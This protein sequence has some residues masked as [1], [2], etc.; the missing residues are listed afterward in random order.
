MK[1]IQTAQAAGNV[2]KT[3][4]RKSAGSVVPLSFIKTRASLGGGDFAD[5][6]VYIQLAHR[7]GERVVQILPITDTG[8]ENYWPYSAISSFAINPIFIDIAGFEAQPGAP[9]DM[10]YSGAAEYPKSLLAL[11][12]SLQELNKKEQIDYVAVR[13]GKLTILLHWFCLLYDAIHPQLVRFKSQ[14]QWVRDYGLF[15]T[16]SAHFQTANWSE[17]PDAHLK[18]HDAACLCDFENAHSESVWFYVFLQMVAFYQLAEIKACANAAGVLLKGDIPILAAPNSVDR[19]AHPGYFLPGY[20]AGAPPDMF[21]TG[22]QAWGNPPL[23]LDNPSAIDYFVSR[24]TLAEHYLD[25]I[26]IDHILGIFRILIWN[27]ALGNVANFGFFYPQHDEK[28]LYALRGDDLRSL[29]L[30]PDKLAERIGVVTNV[31]DIGQEAADVLVANRWAVYVSGRSQI[32]WVKRD[33][34]G[35]ISQEEVSALPDNLDANEDECRVAWQAMGLNREQVSACLSARRL[36][37]NLLIPYL[38]IPDAWVLTFYGR[39]TWHYH[40]L[41]ED[42]RQGLETLVS[43]SYARLHEFWEINGSRYLD[44]LKDKTRLILCG[45]DLGM[46]D[47]YI[48]IALNKLDIPGMIVQRWSATQR[49]TDQ[50]ENAIFTPSTHDTSTFIHWWHNESQLEERQKF[51]SEFMGLPD[52]VPQY[53]SFDQLTRIYLHFYSVNSRLMI[54]PFWEYLTVFHGAD[55]QRINVPGQ[56]LQENWTGRMRYSLEEI[57]ARGAGCD[58]MILAAIKHNER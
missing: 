42:T 57:E 54:L 38:D 18:S 48:P 51:W 40:N 46:V 8:P 9:F 47:P 53:L 25:V 1:H 34:E 3:G 21:T 11:K 22:G 41:S 2:S 28:N 13:N 32:A 7:R 39:E 12:K 6:K 30:S 43:Q 55:D 17:W 33:K 58:Q 56:L 16:I 20:G 4:L 49:A 23:D 44:I 14:H 37:Q 35:E 5:F 29:G 52:P 26:R 27:L 15:C 10:E 24:F 31:A 50:R 19:W 45:E 36:L